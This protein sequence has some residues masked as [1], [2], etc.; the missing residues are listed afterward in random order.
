MLRTQ[1]PL[2]CQYL[3]S[4]TVDIDIYLYRLVLPRF[5]VFTLNKSETR[6]GEGVRGFE[7]SLAEVT[8]F[9]QKNLDDVRCRCFLCLVQSWKR[10]NIYIE[11]CHFATSHLF[12]IFR[13]VWHPLNYLFV[14]AHVLGM[15]SIL[16]CA[17]NFFIKF[18]FSWEGIP[19]FSLI[20]TLAYK[21]FL[22]LILKLR[23]LQFFKVNH[24]MDV[25]ISQAWSVEESDTIEPQMYFPL[26]IEVLQN[27][28]LR[29]TRKQFS[30]F[31]WFFFFEKGLILTKN[32][33]VLLSYFY[34]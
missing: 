12:G 19:F 17:N 34:Y 21:I 18:V 3:S 7:S 25:E 22:G 5:A 23:L 28:V 16:V 29:R 6:L 27:V 9:L 33:V 20:F 15:F 11:D 31:L 8:N 2:K 26:F 32:V 14:S 13:S 1:Q 4:S 10:V 24:T 30:S